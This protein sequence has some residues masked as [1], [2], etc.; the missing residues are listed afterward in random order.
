MLPKRCYSQDVHKVARKEHFLLA[1]TQMLSHRCTLDG[2]VY[3]S[4]EKGPTERAEV[5]PSQPWV[6]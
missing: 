3:Q 1:S 5:L 2:D 6:L 4:V